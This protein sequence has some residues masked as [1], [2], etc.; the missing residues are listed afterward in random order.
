MKMYALD[1]SANGE[2]IF[3]ADDMGSLKLHIDKQND[4]ISMSVTPS[5]GYS[6]LVHNRFDLRQIVLNGRG[7]V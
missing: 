3:C 5:L 2:C 4:I 7:E 1:N 6:S